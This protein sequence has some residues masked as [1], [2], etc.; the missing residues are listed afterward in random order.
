VNDAEYIFVNKKITGKC[1][2]DVLPSFQ[3]VI[4]G[5]SFPQTMRWGRETIRYARPIRWLVA[6][7]GEKVIPF[8][9]ASV[10]TGNVTYGHRFLGEDLVLGTPVDYYNL[11]EQYVI[12]SQKERKTLI[13]EGIVSIEKSENIQVPT[14]EA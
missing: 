3:Q 6:L 8:E 7:Y 13:S 2:E 9:I 5:L 12:T 4:E 14:N 11:R 10:Q 1:T